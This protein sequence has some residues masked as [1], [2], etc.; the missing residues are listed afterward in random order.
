[1]EGMVVV[2]AM[3]GTKVVGGTVGEEV[4]ATKGMLQ[5]LLPVGDTEVEEPVEEEEEGVGEEEIM[6]EVGMEEGCAH[7]QPPTVVVVEVVE[8][9]G[10]GGL[11]AAAAEEEV[12]ATSA[13]T[14]CKPCS[15]SATWRSSG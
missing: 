10:V 12:V 6:V 8:E 5:L 1:M 3:V 9:E 11:A 2:M 7:L 4:V 14:M 13:A 15:P